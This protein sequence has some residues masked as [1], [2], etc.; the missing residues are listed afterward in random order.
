MTVV[1][2]DNQKEFKAYLMDHEGLI[3]LGPNVKPRERGFTLPSAI[4]FKR[5]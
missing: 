5:Q 1:L 4:V 2:A 3:I